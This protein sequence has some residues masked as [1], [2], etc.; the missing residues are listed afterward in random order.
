MN[1]LTTWLI[2]NV[3]KIHIANYQCKAFR[4]VVDYPRGKI[5]M[6]VITTSRNSYMATVPGTVATWQKHVQNRIE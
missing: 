6:W 4:Y 2:G 5:A 3:T 1:I